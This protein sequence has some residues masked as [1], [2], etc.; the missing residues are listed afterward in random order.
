MSERWI[1][2]NAVDKR[3]IDFAV[4]VH[5]FNRVQTALRYA[6]Q[7]V[8]V[9]IGMPCVKWTT[10]NKAIYSVFAPMNNLL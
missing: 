4:L 10:G 3:H 1:S 6:F 2:V 8:H 7:A 5:G 9:V